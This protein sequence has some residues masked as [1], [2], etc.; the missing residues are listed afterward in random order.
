MNHQCDWTFWVSKNGKGSR[1]PKLQDRQPLRNRVPVM[2]VTA[3]HS[4]GEMFLP[5][6]STGPSVYESIEASPVIR[7]CSASRTRGRDR[8][9]VISPVSGTG[10]GKGF[11]LRKIISLSTFSASDRLPTRAQD[12]MMNLAGWRLTIRVGAPSYMVRER[13]LLTLMTLERREPR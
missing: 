7:V 6:T 13:A 1:V 10:G 8:G 2:H 11:V 4:G 5:I 3:S 12:D 9:I